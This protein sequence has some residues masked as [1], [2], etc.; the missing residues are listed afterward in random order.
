[1]QAANLMLEVRSRE[2]DLAAAKQRCDS[3]E[4]YVEEVLAQNEQFRLHIYGVKWHQYGCLLKQQYKC[5]NLVKELCRFDLPVKNE[6]KNGPMVYF[7]LYFSEF[8]L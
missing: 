6:S 3:L 7:P 2:D 1:M 8:P 4:K 5:S